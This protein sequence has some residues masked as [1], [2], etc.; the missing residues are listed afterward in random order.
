MGDILERGFKEV[1]NV[2]E[3]ESIMQKYNIK[4]TEEISQV[5]KG[6]SFKFP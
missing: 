4:D 2:E 6:E 1:L 5:F 3:Q